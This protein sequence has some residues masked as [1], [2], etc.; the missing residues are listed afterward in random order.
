MSPVRRSTGRW[1][2]GE[3]EFSLQN[4]GEYNN[5][6]KEWLT[7]EGKFCWHFY[8]LFSEVL[9]LRISALDFTQTQTL[10]C[11]NDVK[12][13]KPEADMGNPPPGVPATG[14]PGIGG[15]VTFPEALGVMAAI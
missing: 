11:C 5:L 4:G 15:A 2:S 12:E 9:K 14:V 13:G 10:N 7:R 8:D 1:R 3:G 6:N